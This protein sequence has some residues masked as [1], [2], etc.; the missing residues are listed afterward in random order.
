MRRRRN[1]TVNREPQTAT[2][3]RLSHEGRGVASQQGKT[4]FIH[5]ALPGENVV[6]QLKQT[7]N[8]FDEA[9]VISIEQPSAWR[10][11]PPCEHFDLCGGC[12]LQHIKPEQQ[13][14]HKQAVLQE[15]FQHIT[16]QLPKHWLPPLT[17]DSQG[18]RRK[19]RLGV[20]IVPAK[21]GVVLG[22]RERFNTRYITDIQHCKILHPAIADRFPEIKQL[23]A[24]LSVAQNIPQI[25][26][27]VGDENAA[28]IVRHL[29]ALT[30]D[31]VEQLKNFAKQHQINIYSQA[32]GIDSI[33][34]LYPEQGSELLSYQLDDDLT[35]K[36]HP[37]DF[38]Q[39][40]AQMNHK[41]V[42]QALSLL[43]LKQDDT[44]L[45]L[46]CGLG[47]FTL[48]IAKRVAKVVAVEGCEKMVKRGQM[49]AEL[50][51]LSN[52][53]FYSADLTKDINHLGFAKQSFAKL[54]I[55][56]PRSGAY[57]IL[58]LV[59][60]FNPSKIVYVS[61][62]PSTLARDAAYLIEECGYQLTTAGVMDMFPH[63]SHVEAIAVFDKR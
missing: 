28:I 5:G 16:K 44:V 34:L 56:P 3:E 59:K 33:T 11:T 48:P 60:Q 53:E 20:K 63:T 62:N 36:F 41:M 54:L 57:E 8:K 32:A 14:Q 52:V 50:N 46:F 22:F 49:N 35:L 51:Q 38:T 40:N 55:D 61:C 26:I 58:P 25:E 45:D 10:T 43:E 12:S 47:N 19:A 42:A 4:V 23:I 30:D 1:K 13:I 27:A 17:A 6:Y 15:H 21:G 9:D 18:Y 7:H 37:N 29:Q 24:S 31:D 39:V 2:V